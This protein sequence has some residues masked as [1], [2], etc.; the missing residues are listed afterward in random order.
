MISQLG[1]FISRSSFSVFSHTLRSSLTQLTNGNDRSFYW[2]K[3]VEVILLECEDLDKFT[4]LIIKVC[5]GIS[6][7]A[8]IRRLSKLCSK[9]TSR[10]GEWTQVMI[11]LCNRISPRGTNPTA[12]KIV[13]NN[14]EPI[15]NYL[16]FWNECTCVSQKAFAY[17]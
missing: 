10:S 1:N 16:E 5:I 12:D 17:L 14:F 2:R 15:L 13:L 6:L 4:Q 11:R 8:P 7:L 9:I 3:C